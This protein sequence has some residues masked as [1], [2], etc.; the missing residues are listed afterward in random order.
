MA[1]EKMRHE[2]ID[3]SRLYVTYSI[4]H[5][6]DGVT[7]EDIAAETHGGTHDLVVTS[8]IY[9]ED[10]SSST[11]IAS[12]NALG[13]P[14]SFEDQFHVWTLWAKDLSE[15]LPPGGRRDLA[16]AVFDMVRAAIMK[17]RTKESEE[18]FEAIIAKKAVM[19]DKL[20]DEFER[21]EARRLEELD[22]YMKELR[23]MNEDANALKH[24]YGALRRA[25][26]VEDGQHVMDAH[27][28][29]ERLKIAASRDLS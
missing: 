18:V 8:V 17:G 13:E 21:S 24:E 2:Q 1:D 12:K 20:A 3:C 23:K 22:E 29:I 9:S 26:G 6:P 25:L 19:F 10:G 11:M 14:L 7:Y 4:D 16:A 5:H 28:A 27:A 15:G